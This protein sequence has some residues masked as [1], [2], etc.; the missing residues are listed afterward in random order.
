[1]PVGFQPDGDGLGVRDGSSSDHVS[2]GCAGRELG[3]GATVG[4]ASSG[5]DGEASGVV[6]SSLRV[7][8]LDP[9]G[10]GLGVAGRSVVSL[11][12]SDLSSTSTGWV[13]CTSVNADVLNGADAP[14]V[15]LVGVGPPISAATG[16]D[17]STRVPL[18]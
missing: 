13:G 18:A 8:E 4:M 1:V 12:S 16:I 14:E 11:T 5:F 10:E 2:V 6:P 7:V 3:S 17:T 9:P 15:V